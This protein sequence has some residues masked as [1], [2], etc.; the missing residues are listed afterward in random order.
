MGNKGFEW[1]NGDSKSQFLSAP[2]Q[3]YLV[4]GSGRSGF[5]LLWVGFP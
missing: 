5:P 1:E 2:Y 3:H 4:E